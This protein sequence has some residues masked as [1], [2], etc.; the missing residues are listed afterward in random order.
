MQ[1]CIRARAHS[2]SHQAFGHND[3]E[4]LALMCLL[5]EHQSTT[6]LHSSA[7]HWARS[8]DGIV[9]TQ[10][11][12]EHRHHRTE[13]QYFQCHQCSGVRRCASDVLVHIGNRSFLGG[14][15]GLYGALLHSH[16]CNYRGIPPV[17]LAPQLQNGPSVS[18]CH[19]IC[20]R[21][22]CSKRTALVGCASPSSSP[23]LR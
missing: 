12:Y 15:C 10:Y 7:A 18:I 20:R 13:D 5:L 2:T 14:G 1:P 9:S 16:V 11:C 6:L 23:S 4:K 8:S 19:G 21:K 17:L 3:D 22:R